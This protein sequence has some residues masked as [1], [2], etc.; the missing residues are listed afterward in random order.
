MLKNHIIVCK[1]KT[2]NHIVSIKKHESTIIY[3]FTHFYIREYYCY[4]YI[5]LRQYVN[6]PLLFYVGVLLPPP[7]I[8]IIKMS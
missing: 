1:L 3:V 4:P 8:P 5:K 7:S 6:N 2:K